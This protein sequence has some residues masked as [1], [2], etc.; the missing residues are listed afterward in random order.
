MW[1]S[2]FVRPEFLGDENVIHGLSWWDQGWRDN[3]VYGDTTRICCFF[4]SVWPPSVPLLEM[5]GAKLE[6][7]G[8]ATEEF[9]NYLTTS[10]AAPPWCHRACFSPRTPRSRRNPHQIKT[11]SQ[12]AR[13]WMRLTEKRKF[14]SFSRNEIAMIY[15]LF[16]KYWKKYRHFRCYFF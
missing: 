10:V 14:F 4:S 2:R 8:Y 11:H 5:S 15:L 7:F 12:Y 16:L 9:S 6:L 13:K 3:V 1:S